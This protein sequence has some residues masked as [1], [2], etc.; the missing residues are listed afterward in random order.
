MRV[1]VNSESREVAGIGPNRVVLSLQRLLLRRRVAAAPLDLGRR[2][3]LGAGDHATRGTVTVGGASPFGDI[4]NDESLMR[5]AIELQAIE[6]D[7][8]AAK[9]VSF[10]QGLELVFGY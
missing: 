4:P 6:V 1:A 3:A 8:G 7:P 9:G 10:T 2:P 5:F